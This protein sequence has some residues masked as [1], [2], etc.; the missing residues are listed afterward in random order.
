[1]QNNEVNW[2]SY[3]GILCGIRHPITDL[4]KPICRTI[5]ARFNSELSGTVGRTTQK[6]PALCHTKM[7]LRRPRSH[8]LRKKSNGRPATTFNTERVLRFLAKFAA[9]IK[10]HSRTCLLNTVYL[11]VG[12]DGLSKNAPFVTQ[13]GERQSK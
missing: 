2:N 10:Q 7:N 13:A 8:Y 3:P 12:C 9:A 4:V 1:M 5:M 11:P 6:R